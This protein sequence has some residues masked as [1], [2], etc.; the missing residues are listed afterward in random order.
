LS[1]FASPFVLSLLALACRAP[2]RATPPPADAPAELVALTG[3]SI[4]IGVGDIA[5]CNSPWDE[6][7][8]A[9][10]DSVLKADSAAKV[11]DAVFTLGDNAYPDGSERDFALC[12]TPSWGDTAKR[13]IS[14]LRPAPGNHEHETDEAAPYYKYFGDRAGS[15]RKGYYSYNL[16]EW[17]VVVLNSEIVVNRIFSAKEQADQEEWLREDLKGS[18]KKCAVAYFHHPRFSSGWHGGDTRITGLWRVMY[19]GGVD[20]VLVGHDHHYERF[21]PLNSAFRLQG[22]FGV[23][24]LTLGAEEWRSAFIDTKG[25]VW[26]PSGGKCH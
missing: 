26:D 22:H 15:P 13:I 10:V 3:A 12:F 4:L 7:T 16:G 23:I 19:E 18:S 17:H 14:R 24:K 21:E 1:G 2:V 11:E 6:A 20:L 8:A 25:T 5:A 9:I